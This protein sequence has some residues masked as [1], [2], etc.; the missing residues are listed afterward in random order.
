[1]CAAMPHEF[2]KDS[3]RLT[4]GSFFWRRIEIVPIRL[5]RQPDREVRRKT[6]TCGTGKP[7]PY[8]VRRN[9][10]TQPQILHR[11]H[12]KRQ[13]SGFVGSFDTGQL[14]YMYR[15]SLRSVYKELHADRETGC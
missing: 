3:R 7:V 10:V 2:E 1:M 13:F 4:E 8:I 5:L 9:I 11:T 12:G 15:Y 6:I 14:Q